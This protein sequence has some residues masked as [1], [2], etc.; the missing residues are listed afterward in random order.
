MLTS[1]FECV[2]SDSAALIQ[3]F[4]TAPALTK[5]FANQIVSV[6]CRFVCAELWCADPNGPA[7]HLEAL[8]RTRSG[9]RKHNVG[10]TGGDTN[11]VKVASQPPAPSAKPS[12]V[13]WLTCTTATPD[14]LQNYE[15]MLEAKNFC[16]ASCNVSSFKPPPP[17][18]NRYSP[19]WREGRRPAAHHHLS[20]TFSKLMQYYSS[21]HHPRAFKAIEPLWKFFYLS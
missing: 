8:W 6:V 10:F 14:Y 18:H 1:G 12:Q 3:R 16:G 15:I 4:Q 13:R 19:F 11:Q 17:H 5:P 9:Q 2:T 7:G 20:P 21:N